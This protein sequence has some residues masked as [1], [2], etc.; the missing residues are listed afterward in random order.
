MISTV[1]IKNRLCVIQRLNLLF[2]QVIRL[3]VC[4]SLP[5]R[6][7]TAANMDFDMNGE[8]SDDPFPNAYIAKYYG[9][10]KIYVIYPDNSGQ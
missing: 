3:L 4:Q 6:R 1:F 5:P 8:D 9:L 10:D 2:P 7:S